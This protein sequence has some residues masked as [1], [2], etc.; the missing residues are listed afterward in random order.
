MLRGG[1]LALWLAAVAVAQTIE[2]T[3]VDGQS[4]APIGGVRVAI[5]SDGK[6]VQAVNTDHQGAFRVEGLQPAEYRVTFHKNG[7]GPAPGQLVG[8]PF[9]LT[10]GGN[11]VRI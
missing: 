4:G 9:L 8:K 2:G 6:S 3:A 11:S 10:L 7:F 5:E 1:V